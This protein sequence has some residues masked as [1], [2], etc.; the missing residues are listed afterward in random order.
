M[1]CDHFGE[2]EKLSYILD[3]L[4]FEYDSQVEIPCRCRD[5]H[6]KV[7]RQGGCRDVNMEVNVKG[8]VFK[9]MIFVII[10]LEK[11]LGGD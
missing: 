8:M 2:A 6:L 10:I 9:A 1:G 11:K 7:K 5:M 4:N 3:I